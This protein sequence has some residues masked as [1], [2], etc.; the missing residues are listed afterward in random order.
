MDEGM[1][2]T[3]LDVTLD[4]APARV[5]DVPVVR[6][7]PSREAIVRVEEAL[8]RL[9]QEHTD[10]EHFFADGMYGRRCFIPADTVVTGK[11]HRHEHFVLL[12]KGEATINTDK[13]MERIKAPHVWVS[14]PGA[15]RILYTHSD[16]EFFTTHLNH[17]NGRDL[18]AIEAYVIEPEGLIT[19]EQVSEFTDELQRMY[20]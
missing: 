5:I 20:A 6:P 13:G 9:P 12:I 8:S 1:P 16:C 18:E 10:V 4:L 7:A 2:V 3:F 11:I 17:E 14:Q 19:H 15:K